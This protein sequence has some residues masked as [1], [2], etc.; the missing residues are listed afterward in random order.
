MQHFAGIHV[1]IMN[2][3]KREKKYVAMFYLPHDKVKAIHFGHAGMMDYTRYYVRDRDLAE[4]R[5]SLYLQRHEHNEDWGNPMSAGALSRWI[6]WNK[7]TLRES[8]ADFK[9]KFK[10]L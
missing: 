5:K 6:L 1:K 3:S 10:L 9:K 2:S 8:I 4:Y 7:P